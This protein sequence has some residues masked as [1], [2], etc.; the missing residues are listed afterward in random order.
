MAGEE[1]DRAMLEAGGFPN[2]DVFQQIDVDIRL[3]RDVAEA[4]D[5]QLLVGPAGEIIREAAEEGQRQLPA[6]RQAL[7]AAYEPH[8]REDG[9]FMPSSTWA[10]MACK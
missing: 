9:V 5:Y 4:V 8:L 3:G 1:T 6:I 7:H 10:I 2:V